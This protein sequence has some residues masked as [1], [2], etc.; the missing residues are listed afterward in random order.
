MRFV[1]S[2]AAFATSARDAAS[3]GSHGRRGERVSTSVWHRQRHGSAALSSPAS[4]SPPTWSSISA[5]AV[6]VANSRAYRSAF[7]PARRSTVSSHRCRRL[8]VSTF[9][10]KSHWWSSTTLRYLLRHWR[11]SAS[12]ASSLGT[13]LVRGGRLCSFL[14]ECSR[15]T[16][17]LEVDTLTWIQR[18]KPPSSL[19]RFSMSVSERLSTSVRP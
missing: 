17:D 7:S 6:S 16:R 9:G 15:S 3:T 4:S 12:T 19:R 13:A 11:S 10:R 5:R 14:H 18:R 1:S 2:S 8:S